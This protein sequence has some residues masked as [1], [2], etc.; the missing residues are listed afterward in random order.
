MIRGDYE[1]FLWDLVHLQH[2]HH[3]VMCLKAQADF[4]R[5]EW[6]RNPRDEDSFTQISRGK[7]VTQSASELS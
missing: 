2:G 5:E 6:L 1:D 4:I 7:D 3:V